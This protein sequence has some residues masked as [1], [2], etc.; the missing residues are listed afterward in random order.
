[1]KWPSRN[2]PRYTK[3]L[4]WPSGSGVDYGRRSALRR[5]I[6]RHQRRRRRN[7]P[8]R[9][10][11]FTKEKRGVKVADRSHSVPECDDNHLE[12]R[13]DGEVKAMARIP[14]LCLIAA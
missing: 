11:A 9:R 5:S 8:H 2:R 14:V 13:S 4:A 1:M 6:N 10:A 7:V 3:G 12:V